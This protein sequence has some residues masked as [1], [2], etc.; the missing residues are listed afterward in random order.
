MDLPAKVPF[1]GFE[2]NI[3]HFDNQNIRYIDYKITADVIH[4]KLESLDGNP[5]TFN[6]TVGM[7]TPSV[8]FEIVVP[9]LLEVT[10]PISLDVLL[11]GK[12][13]FLDIKNGKMPYDISWSNGA[14]GELSQAFSPGNYDVKV[15]DGNGCERTVL[16]T[17]PEFG[18]I[19][20]IDGNVYETFK[21]G[22]TWWMSENLRT[23]RKNDGSSILFIEDDK[24]WLN[25]NQAAYTWYDNDPTRDETDGKLYNYPAACCNICPSGWSLPTAGDFAV[26][27]NRF[28]VFPARSLRAVNKWDTELT[29][30]TNISS[31]NILPS[32]SRSGYSGSFVN[33][34]PFQEIA[35]LWT[36]SIDD[37]GN[38]YV[39]FMTGTS[40]YFNMTYSFNRNDG[41]S[42]RC[43]RYD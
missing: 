39:F 37:R 16:F 18:T 21:F 15:M 26:L 12:T 27:A 10:C 43:V 23:T 9:S 41:L 33:E 8:S 3:P 11:I 19:E 30:S 35:V 2:W 17:V 20:D 24:D 1:L 4:L 29:G 28:G 34:G 14:K 7:R 38:P 22:N 5:H 31:L 36:N 42:V 6:L 13:H 32:G 25:S 40:D